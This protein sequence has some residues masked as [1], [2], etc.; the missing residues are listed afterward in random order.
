MSLA[1]LKSI[2]ITVGIANRSLIRATLTVLLSLYVLMLTSLLRS[3]VYS[4][5]PLA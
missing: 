2:L 3:N 5:Q 4:L 1:V